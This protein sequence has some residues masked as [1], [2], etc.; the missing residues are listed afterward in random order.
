MP[1]VPILAVVCCAYLMSELSFI[2]WMRFVGW[3]AVGLV[4]YVF[5]GLRRSHLRTA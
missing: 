5:Y 3:L 4:F 2:T 1:A